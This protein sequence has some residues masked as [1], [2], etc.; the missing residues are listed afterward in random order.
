MLSLAYFGTMSVS[1][2]H[3]ARS[4][5]L[6]LTPRVAELLAFLALRR[7][8]F[9]TRPE[10]ADSVWDHSD[11][12]ATVA[13]VN[14]ALWRLRRIIEQAPVQRGDF[15]V[16]NRLGAV[17]L[18]GPR[19]VAVDIADFEALARG[20]L[21]KPIDQVTES[22]CRA[23]R[24]SVELYRDNALAEFT[25]AWALKQR[26]RLRNTFVDAAGRLMRV[27]G[28]RSQYADAIH[29]ARLVLEVDMLRED[30]HRELMHL[31]V[32]NG[33]R[34]LALR[35]F[36]ACRAAL[37]RELAIHPMPETMALYREITDDAVGHSAARQVQGAQPPMF[38]EAPA[39]IRTSSS[40]GKGVARRGTDGA[41]TP[42]DQVR[43]AR[44]LL[45]DA[46]Q[47]LQQTLD[48]IQH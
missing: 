3:T 15:L 6:T 23:L 17:S 20:G 8:Q 46:D 47:C 19:R 24:A 32:L 2:V 40:T 18:N 42:I 10:I 44:S 13:S 5:T 48:L 29:Y 33:Q 43:I 22:D 31:L 38:A 25:G 4:Q 16:I 7:G 34:A 14:T 41:T 30:V 12:D 9:F 28:L 36:E 1:L 39:P 45:A 27:S 26:E 21:S 35:Q 11:C 37:Q